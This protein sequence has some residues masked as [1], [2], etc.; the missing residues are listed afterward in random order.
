MQKIFIWFYFYFLRNL[1][2][3]KI[4]RP[5][6]G[7]HGALRKSGPANNAATNKNVKFCKYLYITCAQI[8]LGFHGLK[9]QPTIH[10][11]A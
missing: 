2:P 8:I 11:A 9:N 10:I 4:F 3:Q 5:R 6:P 7:A 1:P